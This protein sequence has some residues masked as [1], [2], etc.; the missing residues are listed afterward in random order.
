MLIHSGR[1]AMENRG[2]RARWEE[3]ELKE[4]N[5]ATYDTAPSLIAVDLTAPVTLLAGSYTATLFNH[6]FN[7]GA[8]TIEPLPLI[9]NGVN[10]FTTI[11]A[12]A[13]SSSGQTPPYGST[14]FGE[15]SSFTLGSTTMVYA[16][17]YW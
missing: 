9:G 4:S 5:V 16:G 13:T 3:W 14:T 17:L 2:V 6:Q 7:F 8:G 11:A 15:V 12:G 1:G 10:S